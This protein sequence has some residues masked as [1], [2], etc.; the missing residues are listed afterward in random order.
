MELLT[1][2]GMVHMHLT[3][4]HQ[5]QG[6]A[7]SCFAALSISVPIA[8]DPSLRGGVTRGDC[9]N[10]QGLCF[11]IEPCPIIIYAEGYTINEL[12]IY[13]RYLDPGQVVE[14]VVIDEE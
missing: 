8:T 6:P 1:S 13:K 10:G 11:T 2:L 9:S 3:V 14:A 7:L 12:V 5:Q 4:P